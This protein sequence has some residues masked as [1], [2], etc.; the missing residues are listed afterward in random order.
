MNKN[1][2]DLELFNGVAPLQNQVRDFRLEDK[3][4]KQNFHQVMKKLFEPLVDTLEETSKEL[5]KSMTETSKEGSKSKL[6]EKG[7]VILIDSGIKATY[8]VSLQLPSITQK[9]FN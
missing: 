8:S 2:E 1:R 3:P 5:T 6:N 7:S 4:G 9:K